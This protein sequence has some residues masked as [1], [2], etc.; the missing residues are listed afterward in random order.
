MADFIFE[1]RGT[2]IIPRVP[3]ADVKLDGVKFLTEDECAARFDKPADYFREM[4]GSFYG[5]STAVRGPEVET[6]GEVAPMP[7]SSRG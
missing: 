3:Q 5:V 2:E 7:S 6:P 4:W 1:I